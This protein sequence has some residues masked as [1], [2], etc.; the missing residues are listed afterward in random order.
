MWQFLGEKSIKI[1][2]SFMHSSTYTGSMRTKNVSNSF[3]STTPN[4]KLCRK[5]FSSFG[6]TR[7]GEIHSNFPQ[8]L[9]F[10]PQCTER[11][12]SRCSWKV[13]KNVEIRDH[14]PFMRSYPSI[15]PERRGNT[16]FSKN[17]GKAEDKYST[18][19]LTWS[20]QKPKPSH[21]RGLN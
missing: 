7:R 1:N 18:T 14:G 19:E 10:T 9:H 3:L 15:L 2:L 16:A 6:D 13:V 12:L 17:S 21:F 11:K 8:R 5:S 20:V 4:T